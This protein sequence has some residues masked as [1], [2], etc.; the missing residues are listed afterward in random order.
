MKKAFLLFITSFTL[1]TPGFREKAVIDKRQE[2]FAYLLLN[3]IRTSPGKYFK[4]LMFLKDLKIQNTRVK[5]NDTLF[6]VAEAK[7]L[8]MANRDYFSHVDPDGFGMN[9]YINKSGYTLNK[10]W[11]TSK[12]ENNF[13]SI[14][15]GIIDGEDAIRTLII[16]SGV[17][18]LGHRMHLLGVGEWN[19]S[20]VDIGIGY[21]T[22]ERRNTD[23]TYVSVVIAK[24]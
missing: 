13:E 5:W 4:E 9:Y 24:H 10:D 2:Y 11:L 1:N 23:Y 18:S 16:D 3:D 17:P 20:L 19:S 8:D 12:D 15:M 7:A 6:K 21:A 14:A 22:I